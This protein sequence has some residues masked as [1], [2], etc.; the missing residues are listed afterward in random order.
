MRR[1][2]AVK[3]SVFCKPE[4]DRERILAAFRG[5]FP[6]SLEEQ[7]VPLA[8]TKA[9]SFDERVIEMFEA[10]LVKERHTSAF[11]DALL[12]RL[13]PAQ[14]KQLAEQVDSRLHDD[15][16]FFLRFDKDA[17]LN[18]GELWL[19]DAGNC[20]H[21]E[22]VIAAFPKKREVARRVLIGMLQ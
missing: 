22:I 18:L 20:F 9:K 2:T 17:L 7:L 12:A 5:F 15:V 21:V 6:F 11:L 8:V 14:K 3:V 13:S 10:V 16:H 19:T 1:A 4:E